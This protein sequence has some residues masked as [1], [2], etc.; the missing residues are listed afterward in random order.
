M[1][2]ADAVV[3]GGGPAGSTVA[4]ALRRHGL[5]VLVL[6]RSRFPRD[7]VCAGWIT[8]A[9]VRELA[10]DLEAYARG[11]VLQ[12]IRGFRVG[13]LDRRA[14][15]TT[16]H[17]EPVSYG[18]RRCEF[19]HYLLERSGARLALGRGLRQLVRDAGTWTIDGEIRT[20]LVIGAGGHFCPVARALGLA[21]GEA[22]PVVCA[23]EIECE[24]SPAERERSPV[25]PAVPELY[26][27]DDLRGYGW[28][29]RKGDWVNVGL[30]RE[31]RQGLAGHVAAFVRRLVERGR[32][33]SGLAG[34]FRGH[35]YRLYPRGPREVVADGAL[36]VGD[37]AGLAYAESGE[38]IR[39]AVESALLAA[40]T[41]VEA[42]GAYGRERLAPYR[43]RLARRFGARERSPG[44]GALLPRA[45]IE[46]L[47]RR[48]VATRWFADRVVIDRW[49]LH[50]G[51]PALRGV[52]P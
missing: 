19:D 21:P 52:E 47:G 17:D 12:P 32:L 14:V 23:Q 49:F 50:A 11:R 24:L 9:V 15:A 10:L 4:G 42:A 39:P 48:L 33:P 8:P 28:I 46:A 7:K 30:G 40:D 13:A 35:A 27:C 37:A 43:E 34:R 51:I 41:I 1:T 26:F 2:H 18:I 3:V 22:A 44:L 20:P 38:G 29:F 6:D 31:D 5:D 45:A 36:L 25:S 16:L